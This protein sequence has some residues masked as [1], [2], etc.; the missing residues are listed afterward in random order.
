MI[1]FGKRAGAA[2]A[3]AMSM[4]GCAG[5]ETITSVAR[6]VELFALTPKSTF[7]P[8]LPRLRQQIVVS[9][10]TA[11]AAVS[12]DRIAVQPS[13]LQVQYLPDARWVDRAPV[14]VQALLI[15]SYENSGK[16]DAVG[17]SAVGLRADYLIVTELRE[18]QARVQTN[19][20]ADA[21]LQVQVR[22]NMKVVDGFEDRIIASKSFEEF[23]ETA[24]DSPEAIAVAFDEALGDVMRDSVEW[25]VRQMF[26]HDGSSSRASRF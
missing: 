12:S 1:G 6:P 23:M 10:P 14:F 7:A 11:G 5:L 3:L 26:R 4:A 22:L 17:R 24:D 21:P 18:F 13:P 20:A 16:V 9:E 15:E 8:D 2:L 19:L 25:S